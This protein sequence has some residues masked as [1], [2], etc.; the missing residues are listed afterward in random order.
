MNL[1][2]AIRTLLHLCVGAAA[3]AAPLACE[4]TDPTQASI[5]NEFP[6]EAPSSYMI[7]KVWYR[8]T[9]FLDP[10]GPSEESEAFRVGTGSEPVYALVARGPSPGDPDAGSPP[11][12]IVARSR[13]P[14]SLSP[15]ETKRIVLG[16]TTMLLGCGSPNG[17]SQTEYEFIATRLFPGDTVEPFDPAGCETAPTRDA[18]V[19]APSDAAVPSDASA[20]GG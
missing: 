18:G 14:V 7:L 16:P 11:P 1:A 13:D 6:K 17:L 10:I 3:F 8:T 5:A 4:T 9:L 20:D 12:L 2:T 19:D 15:G